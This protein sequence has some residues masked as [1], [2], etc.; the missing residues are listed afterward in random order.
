L[1]FQNEPIDVFDDHIR[2]VENR[3]GNMQLVEGSSLRDIA[4]KII[5]PIIP[6][7]EPEL[8][9]KAHD[10]WERLS[11]KA[12]YDWLSLRFLRWNW[13]KV[14]VEDGQAS[15]DQAMAWELSRLGRMEY[16]LRVFGKL[17][18]FLYPDNQRVGF[19]ILRGMVESPKDIAVDKDGMMGEISSQRDLSHSYIFYASDN[20]CD[21]FWF[22]YRRR[23]AQL[24]RNVLQGIKIEKIRLDLMFLEPHE[25]MIRG[26]RTGK[27][28]PAHNEAC[29]RCGH[30]AP[31]E[32]FMLNNRCPNQGCDCPAAWND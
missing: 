29:W 26:V 30:I 28:C 31:Y 25:I 11:L 27:I 10:V 18:D 7:P 9:E 2:G 19:T 22:T 17:K 12:R 8:I 21:T 1:N 6:W 16:F 15:E 32:V 4:V 13:K 5:L 23:F 24:A 14:E 3:I 20:F